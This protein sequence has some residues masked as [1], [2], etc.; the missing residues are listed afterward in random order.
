M[1]KL[2]YVLAALLMLSVA[3]VFLVGMITLLAVISNTFG[4]V[5]M[6]IFF[7]I[8]TTVTVAIPV[9]LAIEKEQREAR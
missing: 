7:C 3:M 9:G 1:R 5:G 8:L 4:P 2:K 6:I